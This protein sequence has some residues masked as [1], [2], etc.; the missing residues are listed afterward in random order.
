MGGRASMMP[1]PS[2]GASDAARAQ[3]VLDEEEDAEV[4][5]AYDTL[6]DVDWLEEV[7]TL[8]TFFERLFEGPLS[9]EEL[10]GELS[11]GTL[12]LDR[13]FVGEWGSRA[14]GFEGHV[15]R[16]Y[17][18]SEPRG[19]I[20]Q[21][22]RKGEVRRVAIMIRASAESARVTTMRL[23][24]LPPL[25][26]LIADMSAGVEETRDLYDRMTHAPESVNMF[27]INIFEQRG[28]SFAGEGVTCYR[29]VVGEYSDIR[30]AHKVRTGFGEF[31]V[32]GSLA[33]I[34]M[35]D[36]SNGEAIQRY[37]PTQYRTIK[38]NLSATLLCRLNEKR[39]A[40]RQDIQT[41]V[42]RYV[43]AAEDICDAH[44]Y[45]ALLDSL[46]DA[47]YYGALPD[48]MRCPGKAL[49]IICLLYTSPSPRD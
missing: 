47:F 49:L 48:D 10:T 13:S 32:A 28:Q 37:N 44:T 12:R 27:A 46:A 5:P 11:T 16:W 35:P 36:C 17:V 1:L 6:D 23:R 25:P 3:A 24:L 19:R 29:T 41:A 4:H 15:E 40:S 8:S 31:V 20:G 21:P 45:T 39:G 14:L 26:T 34:C 7:N 22:L 43:C 38:Q 2:D 18:R 42:A 30:D 33:G 9:Q